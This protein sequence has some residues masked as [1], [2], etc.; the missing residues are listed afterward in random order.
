M[1]DDE[2]YEIV[3]PDN[4]DLSLLSG[5]NSGDLNTA[6]SLQKLL[7]GDLR[8]DDVASVVES[9][10]GYVAEQL[11]RT[12]N[13]SCPIEET[14]QQISPKKAETNDAE[15][16]DIKE[17]S[18]GDAAES[19]AKEASGKE[20]SAEE[21]AQSCA[22]EETPVA[23]AAALVEKTPVAD[24]AALVEK[25]P[26]ADA[27]ALV[28]KTPVA[29]AAA[30]V[31]ETP[32]EASAESVDQ[33]ETAAVEACVSVGVEAAAAAVEACECATGKE[34]SPEA[35]A[36]A[37]PVEQAAEAAAGEAAG[38]VIAREE[39][40]AAGEASVS[41]LVEEASAPVTVA[42]DYVDDALLAAVEDFLRTHKLMHDSLVSSLVK[43]GRHPQELVAED[44]EALKQRLR[45]LGAKPLPLKRFLM[46]IAQMRTAAA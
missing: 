9:L 40:A 43:L 37:M 44:G 31:E 12:A 24:A 46:H 14:S 20:T 30:L 19:V 4:F 6:I 17:T 45:V 23:D 21:A 29:D 39:E 27:A 2:G 32:A 3:L 11:E 41:V 7:Q 22:V 18:T 25:A 36:A 16:V 10:R 34:T 35:P 15:S 26:T 33:E 8:G 13:A 1:E 42:A 28:E 5:A 38:G